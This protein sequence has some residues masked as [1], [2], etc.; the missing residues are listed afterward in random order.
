MIEVNIYMSTFWMI[1][2]QYL[3]DRREEDKKKS[4]LY[5]VL[6]DGAN[7]NDWR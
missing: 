6:Y 3:A 4:N 5:F 7:K 1:Y 2:W